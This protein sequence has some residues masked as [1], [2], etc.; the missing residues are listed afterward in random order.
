MAAVGAIQANALRVGRFLNGVVF[1]KKHLL[2]TNMTISTLMGTLGDAIQQQ[3][4]ILTT[5]LEPK[6]GGADSGLSPGDA[7][8]QVKYSWERASHMSAAGLTTGLVS[9]F[10]YIYLDKWMGS[11]RCLKLITKKVLLDQIIF[12]PINLVV[13]FS[14]IGFLER[15]SVSRIREEIKEKGMEQIYVVEWFIWPPAQFFNF[16]VLPLKYRILFDNFISLGFDIYSPYVKYKTELR[17]E[18]RLKQQATLA[19][20]TGTG[21]WIPVEQDM[22]ITSDLD[23][24]STPSGDTSL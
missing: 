21:T 7:P 23:L 6:K 13:Y 2:M 11:Q 9:H 19:A 22:M 16:Y 18:K 10:W 14:T 24:T 17:R 12:S 4:D 15:S 20:G 1:G 5:A 8:K 3:Y